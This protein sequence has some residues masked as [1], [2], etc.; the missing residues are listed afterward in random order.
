MA[1]KSQQKR[2]NAVLCI[3]LND[4]SAPSFGN[5]VP[6]SSSVVVVKS[7][8]DFIKL[9]R[10]N[11]FSA[12]CISTSNPFDERLTALRQL[13]GT[14]GVKHAPIL[15]SLIDCD[16]DWIAPSNEFHAVLRGSEKL[17]GLQHELSQIQ[18]K[19]ENQ[20]PFESESFGLDSGQNKLLQLKLELDKHTV[21]AFDGEFGTAKRHCAKL[22]YGD[23]LLCIDPNVSI[24]DLEFSQISSRVIELNQAAERE[25][26]SRDVQHLISGG[27]KRVLLHT[28]P[29]LTRLRRETLKGVRTFSFSPLRDRKEDFDQ[30]LVRILIELQT[31][32]G[33]TF[34]I[35]PSFVNTMRKHQWPGN[36]TELSLRLAELFAQSIGPENKRVLSKNDAQRLLRR[37]DSLQDIRLEMKHKTES[38]QRMFQEKGQKLELQKLLDTALLNGLGSSLWRQKPDEVSYPAT[39]RK[40][41]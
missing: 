39:E 9:A 20:D 28:E 14:Q 2:N 3:H 35:E 30:L 26:L 23:T 15:L 34:T 1:R 4:E 38:V 24:A 7:N 10:V 41:A 11:Q 29:E 36:F 17:E 31:R 18:Q 16:L 13:A 33:E 27:A 22:L 37:N 40:A 12:W 21:I 8:D 19:N 32:F 6:K 25:F 5:A